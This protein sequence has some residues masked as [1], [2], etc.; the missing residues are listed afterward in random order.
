MIAVSSIR[1][2]WLA[3]YRV[4]FRKGH[5]GLLAEAYSLGLEPLYG[6]ALLFIS[7]DRRKIKLLYGDATG[8]WVCYKVFHKS[9]MKSLIDFTSEKSKEAL[10]AADLGMLLEGALFSVHKRVSPFGIK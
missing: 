2:I 5:W 6:D 4:D 7:R 10:T 8:L 3:R 1:A 9:A